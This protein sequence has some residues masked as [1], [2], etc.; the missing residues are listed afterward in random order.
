[1]AT[2]HGGQ[3]RDTRHLA[4][5]EGQ[6]PSGPPLAFG[7]DA[8]QIAHLLRPQ[9]EI[10]I[11]AFIDMPHLSQ[12]IREHRKEILAGWETF[13]RDLPATSSMAVDALRDHAEAMLCAI[14]SD[15]ERPESEQERVD[16]ALGDRDIRET[17]VTAASRHGVGRAASG[18][19]VESMLAEFRALRASVISLWRQQQQHAGPDELEE[20]TRFNEAIDQ[21]IAESI[22]RYTS[23][24]E[25][26]R[27]RFF[28]V[29][30]HDLRTPLGVILTSSQFLLETAPLTDAQRAVVA[31]ME[32]SGQRMIELVKDLLDLALTSMGTGIPLERTGMDLGELLGEVVAEVA[33]SGADSRIDVETTGPLDGAWDKARLAQAFSNLI[34]NAVQHGLPNTPIEV[35]AE[36]DDPKMV[37]VS[38][39]NEGPAIPRDQIGGLFDAMK[40]NARGND[41][42]HLGLGLYIVDKIVEAHGGS[43]DVRSSEG[44]GTTFVILLPRRI[45]A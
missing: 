2:G 36:G 11:G 4:P 34:A 37:K 22:A 1:M 32:R 21:A 7:A 20:L 38:V 44:Q 28:A 30:G 12:F 15:L 42:R 10:A 8:A 33:A 45:S 18:F 16:K 17:D 43:I 25:T 3:M 31:G 29:L 35:T 13:A 9:R 26:A 5:K 24:V 41:R 39:T 14:A 23:E 19:S 40:S 27:D 6:L